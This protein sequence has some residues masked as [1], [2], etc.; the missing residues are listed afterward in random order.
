MNSAKYNGSA[1]VTHQILKRGV[2]KQG[3]LALEKEI[4]HDL[5]IRHD[6]IAA[7]HPLLLPMIIRPFP[8][9]SFDVGCYVQ[10]RTKVMRIVDKG[11]Q[12]ASCRNH[13]LSRIFAALDVLS[14][15]SCLNIQCLC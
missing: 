9:I 5:E 11:L 12:E 3:L 7:H 6:S 1:A 15:L 2:K 14:G 4:L 13:D 10:A 8:W